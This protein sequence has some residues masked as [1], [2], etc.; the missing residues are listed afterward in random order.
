MQFKY[1]AIILF[2]LLMPGSY[3]IAQNIKGISLLTSGGGKSDISAYSNY[4]VLG[5][6][7][8]PESYTVTG[9]NN[10]TG[11]LWKSEMKTGLDET[12]EPRECFELFPNPTSG[13]VSFLNSEIETYNIFISNSAGVKIL[14]SN[15][16][17]I[18]D[19]SGL[20]AGLYIL[21]IINKK[22]IC[23]SVKKIIKL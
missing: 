18:I 14:E 2:C 15:F 11:L 9:Y 21:K 19:I 3:S 13:L 1:S 4:G 8:Y 22:G 5:E 20:P 16:Q 6:T 23:I 17:D 10:Y 12:D 7:F